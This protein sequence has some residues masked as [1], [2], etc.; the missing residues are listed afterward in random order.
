MKAKRRESYGTA[1]GNR[2]EGRPNLL[3]A[4]SD[5]RHRRVGF[6]RLAIVVPILNDWRR[7][8]YSVVGG[9][10]LRSIRKYWQ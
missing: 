9:S 1:R 8:I 4:T 2:K 5:T 3:K 10:F 7:G 6:R